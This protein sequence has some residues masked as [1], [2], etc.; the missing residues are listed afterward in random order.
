MIQTK[1][2]ELQSGGDIYQQLADILGISRYSAKVMLY[3][4]L[5]G[6]KTT[7]PNLKLKILIDGTEIGGV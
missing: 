3:P 1:T 7:L 5:Y 4:I 2:I 6:H